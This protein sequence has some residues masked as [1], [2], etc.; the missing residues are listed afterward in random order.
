MRRLWKRPRR[1]RGLILPMT[2]IVVAMTSALAVPMM[3]FLSTVLRHGGAVN[4]QFDSLY[5]QDAATEDAIYQMAN[6]Q[7]FMNGL[8]NNGSQAYSQTV[9]GQQVQVSVQLNNAGDPPPPADP[10]PSHWGLKPLSWSFIQPHSINVAQNPAGTA[11]VTYYIAN[12]GFSTVTLNQIQELIPPS[13]VYAGNFSS[14]GF[15]DGSNNPMSLP[16]P[17]VNDPPWTYTGPNPF[18]SC[19][20]KTSTQVAGQKRLSWSWASSQPRIRSF[21]ST[22]VIPTVSFDIQVTGTPVSGTYSDAPWVY[23]TSQ[24][25]AGTLHAGMAGTVQLTYTAKVSCTVGHKH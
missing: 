21:W 11:H 2:L 22:F 8:Q 23:T 20:N 4:G 3:G 1:E 25:C 12:F 24:Q 15:V 18:S 17:T 16:A 5:A 9:N 13:F 7:S 14:Q 6:S 10:P 19:A